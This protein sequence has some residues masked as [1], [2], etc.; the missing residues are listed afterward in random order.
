M[1]N[2]FLFHAKKDKESKGAKDISLRLCFLM[3]FIA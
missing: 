1:G 2:V 3:S